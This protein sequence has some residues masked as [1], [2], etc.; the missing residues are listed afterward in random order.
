MGISAAVRGP[1]LGDHIAHHQGADR[2]AAEQAQLINAHHPG[3]FVGGAFS[4]TTERDSVIAT[5]PPSP[6]AKTSA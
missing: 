1:E 2:H 5:P 4:C 3:D 6:Q